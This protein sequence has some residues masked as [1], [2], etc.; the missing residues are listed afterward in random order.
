MH[1]TAFSLLFDISMQL[2]MPHIGKRAIGRTRQLSYHV[3]AIKLQM[4][5]KSYQ[6]YHSKGLIA[7]KTR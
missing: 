3:T 6:T 5:I 1:D 2:S 4:Q 7:I